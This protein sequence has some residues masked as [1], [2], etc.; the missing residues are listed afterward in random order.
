MGRGTILSELEE[1]QEIIRNSLVGKSKKTIVRWIRRLRF[2]PKCFIWLLI[3]FLLYWAV[4]NVQWSAVFSILTRLRLYHV[5]I[6]VAVNMLVLFT[7]VGRWWLLLYS[8]QY[9]V[10]PLLLLRYWLIG[11]AF[12]YLI[13]G[14][15]MGGGIFQVY[16]LQHHHDISP[17]LA[18][19]S[20]TTSKVL[21]R[22]GNLLFLALGFYTFTHF[23]ILSGSEEERLVWLVIGIALLPFGYLAAIW[24]GRQPLT[25]LFHHLPTKW[26]Q[27]PRFKK[28]AKFVATT[29]S[30][31]MQLCRQAPLVLVAGLGLT[32]LSWGFVLFET[33]LALTFLELH[34]HPLDVVAIVV[35]VQLAFLVPVPVGLGSVEAALVAIFQTLGFDA[36]Q[37]ISLGLLVRV[38]DMAVAGLGL[39]LGG[40]AAWQWWRS[41]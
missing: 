6:L 39:W 12:S 10:S 4:R 25:A 5:L 18:T 35:A 30:K 34:V 17:G 31:I 1:G 15:Q 38:R 22:L 24:N 40:Q 13:P 28:A 23:R 16:F 11:F 14:P 32:L 29:E 21:E 26:Q 36:S 20:V 33:W 3:A 8:Q 41:Q 9:R 7:F 27:P 19:A 37:A 2:K